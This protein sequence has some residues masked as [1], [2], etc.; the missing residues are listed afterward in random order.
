MNSAPLRHPRDLGANLRLIDPLGERRVAAQELPL[1]VGGEGARIAVPG[2]ERDVVV[3]EIGVDEDGLYVEAASVVPPSTEPDAAQAGAGPEAPTVEIVPTPLAGALRLNGRVPPVRQRLQKGDVI[4]AGD[5]RIFVD[6]E[7]TGTTLRVLHLADNATAAPLVEDLEAA[8]AIDES[9]T[10]TISRARFRQFTGGARRARAPVHWRF[11]AAG[12]AA[13]VAL[14]LW[15]FAVAV[16]VEVRSD[17]ANAEVDFVGAWP[18]FSVGQHHLLRAG[19]YTMEVSQEGFETLRRQVRVG[20]AADPRMTAKLVRLPGKVTFDTKGIQAIALVDGKLVGNLPGEHPVPAGEHELVVRAPRYLEYKAKVAIEGGGLPQDIEVLL[21]PMFSP[22]T[23]ESKPAGA[24]VTVDEREVGVTPVTTEL[25]AGS[26][27]LRLAAEGFKAWETAIQVQ[28]DKPQ[29]IGPVELGLPDGKLTV[30]S[31][32]AQADVAIAGRYRGRTPLELDLAPG[33]E[34]DIVIQ[35]AGYEPAPRRVQIKAAERL[36]LD[37][38]L[39]PVLGEVTVRGEPADAVLYIAGQARGPANQTLKLPAVETSLEVRKEGLETFTTSVTPQ[40]GLPRLVEYRLLSPEQKRASRMPAVVQL[41]NGTELKL[42]PTGRFQMGSPRREPGRR[43]NESQRTLTLQRPFYLGI[44]EVTNAQYRQFR[45]EH[46][47]GVL[48]E[49]SLDLDRQPVVSVNWREAVEFCNWLSEQNRLPP[50]YVLNGEAMVAANPMTTGFRLPTEAEWE[51]AARNENGVA[52]RRYPWGPALP[53]APNSGNYADMAAVELIGGAIE[54]YTDP[55]LVSAP[56][57][58]FAPN[59]LGLY[60]MGGNAAEWIH[61]FYTSY[62]DLSKQTD[63]DPMGPPSG[64]IHVVRGS[65]WRTAN[66]AELRLAYRDGFDGR[67]Q[68]VGFRV[69]R[70]AE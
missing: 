32:P 17:P 7:S 53:V 5:A 14:V 41:N 54:G 27:T 64:Q 18:E 26:Y 67:S 24:V 66:I 65:H 33:V 62:V 35:R 69:A 47:S 40:P 51:W 58:S 20:G 21:K 30:R 10:Q 11:V 31:T 3:G 60:D 61:D 9:T 49:K 55:Y 37:I 6:A 46:L 2:V 8:E 56:V 13:L 16:S 42:M 36:A 29:R 59:T 12:A 43:A 48:G 63:V 45:K 4:T 34:H 44:H 23:I 28:A 25:D 1:T 22:V 39:R 57:G 68:H 52:S 70:Y 38:S 19:T 15:F 50:A